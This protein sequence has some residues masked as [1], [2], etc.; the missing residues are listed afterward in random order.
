MPTV[1]PVEQDGDAARVAGTG[2]VAPLERVRRGEHPVEPDLPISSSGMAPAD[3]SETAAVPIPFVTAA[4]IAAARPPVAPRAPDGVG[5]DVVVRPRSPAVSAPAVD[6]LAARPLGLGST[7]P[8]VHVSIGR[9]EVRA[10][11]APLAP[12]R[13][14]VTPPSAAPSL[15]E[16]LRARNG[17]AR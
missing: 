12:E 13:R 17:R 1:R 7:L 5:P 2:T 3:A 14:A 4:Q 10:V 9:I 11:Q 8:V 16:Y 6:R 15:E